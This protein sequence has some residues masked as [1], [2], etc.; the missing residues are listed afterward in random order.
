MKSL[1]SLFT[2]LFNKQNKATADSIVIEETEIKRFPVLEAQDLTVGAEDDETAIS[3]PQV[4][5]A[6]DTNNRPLRANNRIV[7]EAIRDAKSRLN[8]INGDGHG[9]Q[10]AC[11]A[12]VSEVFV[13]FMTEHKVK[14]GGFPYFWS[15]FLKM[16]VPY[17]SYIPDTFMTYINESNY[18][19]MTSA[20][21]KMVKGAMKD[22]DLKEY[23]RSNLYGFMETFYKYLLEKFPEDCPAM[24]SLG[25]AYEGKKNYATARKCY[26]DFMELADTPY[27]NGL[28]SLLASYEN[29][30]KNLLKDRE[31][32]RY[33]NIQRVRKLN[34]IMKATYEYW[35]QEIREAAENGGND[36]RGEYISFITNY[37]RFEIYQNR[38]DHAYELLS[39]VPEDY[40]DLFRVYGEMGMLYQT[41]GRFKENTYYDLDKAIE[42]F[43]KAE[44]IF[45]SV[46]IGQHDAKTR[47]KCIL[48]PLAN[49]YFQVGRKEEALEVCNKVLLLD[50]QEW[51]AKELKKRIAAQAA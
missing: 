13:L 38:F 7:T 33:E 29:E 25:K 48:M 1:T 28:S 37:A 4:P 14:E 27:N 26:L 20:F 41:K 23:E 16:A 45:L 51:R 9:D 30:V 18:V 42:S 3:A 2:N 12:L 15:R 24:L 6:N 5:V 35:E 49:T 39:T 21:Q 32:D 22:K 34:G 10:E 40:P 17:M 47:E 36:R 46:G 8:V 11:A 31:G 19:L 43:C 50:S 44:E